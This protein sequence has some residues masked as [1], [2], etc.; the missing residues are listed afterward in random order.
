MKLSQ[1]FSKAVQ[2]YRNFGQVTEATLIQIIGAKPAQKS[3][4]SEYYSRKR[5]AVTK[6]AFVA[7]KM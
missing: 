7:G 5:N 3:M 6:I 2:E 4:L 1:N